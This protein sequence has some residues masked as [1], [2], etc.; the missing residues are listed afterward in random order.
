[1]FPDLL[2]VKVNSMKAGENRSMWFNPQYNL[3]EKSLNTV[4]CYVRAGLQSL[5]TVDCY[6]RA[7]LQYCSLLL[8]QLF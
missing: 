5:N 6:V 1:M 3:L 2:N 8:F 4:D 7:G